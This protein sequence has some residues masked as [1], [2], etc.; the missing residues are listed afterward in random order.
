MSGTVLNYMWVHRSGLSGTRFEPGRTGEIA[1]DVPFNSAPQNPDTSLF[2]W[3]DSHRVMPSYW[4]DVA[5]HVE[6]SRFK[7]KD[8]QKVPA[9]AERYSRHVP[10]GLPENTNPLSCRADANHDTF[11]HQVDL[12]R[13]LVLKHCLEKLNFEN[14]FYS[15]VDIPNVMLDIS[16][17]QNVFNTYGMVFG[18]RYYGVGDGIVENQFIGFHRSSVDFLSNI[19]LPEMYEAIDGEKEFNGLYALYRALEKKF[20][21]RRGDLMP[22]TIPKHE[23]FSRPLIIAPNL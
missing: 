13:I 11:W 12:A 14:A 21:E 10:S 16:S 18:A 1:L 22:L 17:L 2:L 6:N 4:D 5:R 23:G 3:L 19:L 7:L 9:Y 8:L 15:D 20:P